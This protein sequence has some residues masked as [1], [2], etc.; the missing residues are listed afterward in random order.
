MP[1]KPTSSF[2]HIAREWDKKIGNGLKGGSKHT[3][4]ATLELLGSLKGK[5]IYEIACGNGFLARL[6]LDRGA[7]EVWASDVSRELIAIAQEAYPSDGIR[8]S[9]REACDIRKMPKEYFDVVVIH[10][11]LF[12]IKDID[13]LAKALRRILAPGG[14]VVS[15][16]I[17]PLFPSAR[18]DSGEQ[19][20]A[21]AAEQDYLKIYTKVI[22]RT[23]DEAE[24]SY[25]TYKRP[26]GYYVSALGRAGLPIVS[27]IE[28]PSVFMREGKTVTSRIPS[29][30]I[31]KAV[32]MGF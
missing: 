20:D 1:K 29:S 6:L 15:T 17:H 3:V 21:I 13:L 27:M 16:L 32:K 30:I 5:K 4:Q 26:L 11:G 22:N 23:W 31:M 7:G 14:T 12:Y 18:Q 19:I 9:V 25:L 24:V 8:Y 10:Q 2:G 28:T